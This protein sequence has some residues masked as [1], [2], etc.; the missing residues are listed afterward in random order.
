MPTDQTLRTELSKEAERIEEDSTFSGK[1]HYNAVSRWRWGHR[2]LGTVSATGSAFAAI[3]VLK[4]WGAGWAIGAAAVSTL[5]SLVHTTLR[6]SE[7]ADRHQRAADRYLAIKNRARIYRTIE[8]LAPDA[9]SEQLIEE[10]KLMSEDV[11]LVGSGA[12]VI[13]RHAY[14]KAKRDIETKRSTNYRADKSPG[15]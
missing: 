12:P 9:S 11:A 8:L 4:Q 1:G 15:S 2:L 6:P 13:P 3:A 7:E 14:K 10:I 5:A